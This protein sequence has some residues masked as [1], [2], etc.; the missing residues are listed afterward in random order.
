MHEHT[1]LDKMLIESLHDELE[2]II[3]YDRMYRDACEHHD[4]ETAEM[5]RNIANDE[6]THAKGLWHKLSDKGVYDPHVH[7]DIEDKWHT[8]KE[9]FN[10]E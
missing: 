9:I 10:L 7:T 6:Y 1:D 2:D 8:V 4:Y 3:K 5:L